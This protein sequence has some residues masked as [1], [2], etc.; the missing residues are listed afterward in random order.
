M[1]DI[2][3]LIHLYRGAFSIV[4]E[5]V[6]KETGR[7]VAIK[8]IKTRFIKNKLLI[9]EIDIMKKV[10][11]HPNI[12]KL[13]EVY[14]TKNYLYLV[15]ELVTGIHS[16]YSFLSSS[17]YFSS[18]SSLLLVDYR[19]STS[20]RKPARARNTLVHLLFSLSPSSLF[21]PDGQQS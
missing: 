18:S 7:R 2:L 10:G 11:N 3:I 8:A 5:G 1:C 19:T 20:S 17:L 16:P 9:R 6:H 15:L 21:T 4:R 13:Y 12:L 14:E